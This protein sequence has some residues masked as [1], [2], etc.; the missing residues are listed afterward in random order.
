VGCA[1]L[2]PI[3]VGVLLWA[4]SGR[5]IVGL[6]HLYGVVCPLAAIIFGHLA[7][8]LIKS[9]PT[10]LRG[11]VLARIGLVIGYAWLLSI[12]GLLIWF[13]WGMSQ[14]S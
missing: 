11:R 8:N 2:N 12:V 14:F 1:I 13:I 6:N 4:L 3:F 9:S 10:P 5:L 7:L